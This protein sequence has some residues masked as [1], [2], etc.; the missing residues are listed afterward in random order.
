M[1]DTLRA[2]CPRAT[3]PECGQDRAVTKTGR[4]WAHDDPRT[5]R[6][7]KGTGAYV[8]EDKSR[9]YSSLCT[10]VYND[11]LR[12]W[13][14][15]VRELKRRGYT[16]ANRSALLRY[17]VRQLDI[18][19]IPPPPPSGD[20]DDV[21]GVGR[22]ACPKCNHCFEYALTNPRVRRCPKCGEDF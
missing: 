17:A 22:A 12:R 15:F 13:D 9:D 21:R 10:S 18:D 8:G 20:L 1:A 7:C 11:D 16:K 19:D 4:L 14:A 2:R 3:C 5:E 6:T